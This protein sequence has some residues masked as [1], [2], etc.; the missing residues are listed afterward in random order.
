M[1]KRMSFTEGFFKT[2][3][4]L[5]GQINVDRSDAFR[6]AWNNII[7]DTVVAYDTN[8]WETGI[9]VEGN[10]W[11]IVE[12]YEDREEAKKGH[13]KWVKRMKSNPRCELKDI[14]LWRG[15]E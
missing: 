10:G 5:V 12:Q 6:D 13:A 7:V 8:M 11:V 4:V 9:M 1:V 2:L 14:D 3:Q 15:N